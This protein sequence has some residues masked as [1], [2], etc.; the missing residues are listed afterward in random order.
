MNKFLIS[1]T[2]GIV[3]LIFIT[4]LLYLQIQYPNTFNILGNYLTVIASFA[5]IF[6]ACFAVVTLQNFKKQ[7]RAELLSQLSKEKIETID[8]IGKELTQIF[9]VIKGHSFYLNK[10]NILEYNF[11][12]LSSQLQIIKDNEKLLDVC[13]NFNREFDNIYK[14]VNKNNQ[15]LIN[16]TAEL[17]SQY[18]G[19][20]LYLNDNIKEH[21]YL[22]PREQNKFFNNIERNQILF[23]QIDK[24]LLSLKTLL[25]NNFL[26]L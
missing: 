6:A 12:S 11:T 7:K 26:Y 19:L 2:I 14:L 5:T 4:I 24:N 20:L 17:L 1:V 10:N 8:F 21:G 3:T 16:K 23:K 13:V 18:I 15:Y 22:D 9:V 25:K